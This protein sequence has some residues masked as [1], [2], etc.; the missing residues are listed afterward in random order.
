MRDVM[1]SR[2]GGPRSRILRIGNPPMLIARG[3]SST[4]G[5]WAQNIAG[6]LLVRASWFKIPAVNLASPNPAFPFRLCTIDTVIY[7]L[8]I[9]YPSKEA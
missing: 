4:A 8:R 1:H 5:R 2:P 3:T 7:W 9:F 6:G